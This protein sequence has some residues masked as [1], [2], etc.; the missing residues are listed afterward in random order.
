[1]PIDLHPADPLID[2]LVADLQPVQ[3]RRWTREVAVIA[4]LVVAEMLIHVLLRG[5]RPDMPQAMQTPMFWWKA[6]SLGSIAG[7]A[8]AAALLSLDPAVTRAPRLAW[9]WR[10]LALVVPLALASGWLIDAGASGAAA[11]LARLDWRDGLDCL[12]NVLLLS[13]P[14]LL[15]LARFVKHGASTRPERS[16]L[17]AGL[18]AAG[19][20]AFVFAFHC[21]HD[22]PLYVTIWYGGAV[23]GIAGM[24]RLLLP[25]LLRW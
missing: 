19:L 20:G 8:M 24:A 13:L 23:L 14:P 12:A 18:A 15:V 21:N 16:A 17:A 6:V 3:P 11:L 25:R 5:L 7:L 2:A 10:G 9:L 22:D 4:G 1:M